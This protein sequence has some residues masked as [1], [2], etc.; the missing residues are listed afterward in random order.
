V[1]GLAQAACSK[2]GSLGYFAVSMGDAIRVAPNT[3]DG[4]V[5]RSVTYRVPGAN[6]GLQYSTCD[7]GGGFTYWAYRPTPVVNNRMVFTSSSGIGYHS[8]LTEFGAL[9]V[10]RAPGPNAKPAFLADQYVSVELVKIGPIQPGTYRF[11][12]N[13]NVG[14]LFA[15]DAGQDY[16][17][18][19]GNDFVVQSSS[20][21]VNTKTVSVD[22]GAATPKEL[23]SVGS[24]S[25]K[26]SN[27]SL[28]LNCQSGSNVY[29]TLTDNQNPSNTSDRLGL[30]KSSSGSG[31]AIQV[32][33]DGVPV[34]FG[35]DSAAAGTTN[36]MPLGAAPDGTLNV[37]LAA[38]F[39]RTGA[40]APGTVQSVATFT[41]S[42]Q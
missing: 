30:A 42:Y 8:T 34:N 29:L 25:P 11:Q 27:F 35:P 15:G 33:K 18:V 10:V 40:L 13:G 39:V 4:T 9:D 23:P 36:Q 32:L 24:V 7:A 21:Q 20:C 12:D 2:V 5:L 6:A 26:L 37:P 28:Q 22:L 1:P 38:R 31:V 3:P 41:F 19:T 16:L 17:T 14:V